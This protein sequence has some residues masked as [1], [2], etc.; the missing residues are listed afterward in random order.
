MNLRRHIHVHNFQIQQ[1][2]GGSGEEAKRL[3]I[4]VLQE[5]F[6]LYERESCKGNLSPMDLQNLIGNIHRYAYMSIY[7]CMR[8]LMSWRI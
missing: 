2:L 6:V 8:A 1:V 5:L 7:V 4:D 3:A